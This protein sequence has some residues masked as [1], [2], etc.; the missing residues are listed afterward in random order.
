MHVLFW[1]SVKMEF[2][3]LVLLQAAPAPKNKPCWRLSCASQVIYFC[4]GWILK[5]WKKRS[6]FFISIFTHGL[7]VNC[8]ARSNKSRYKIKKRKQSSREEEG[9]ELYFMACWKK[10]VHLF[11]ACVRL[12]AL[13]LCW[14]YVQRPL[15][16][17]T[18]FVAIICNSQVSWL[19]II[20]SCWGE[21]VCK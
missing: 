14:R 8:V 12:E 15:L 7:H 9:S 3:K 6:F 20:M 18:T 4:N 2:L 13:S 10:C 16:I 19:H 1:A 21:S 17:F 11:E 5:T